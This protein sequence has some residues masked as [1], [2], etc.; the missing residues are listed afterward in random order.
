[1]D[2]SQIAKDYEKKKVLFLCTHNAIRSQMAEALLRALYGEYYDVYSAG[3]KPTKVHP[4]TIKV[5]KEIGIDISQQYSK[6]IE[7]FSGW[8]F[9]YVITV[10]DKAK[11]ECPFFP[12]GKKYL[13]KSFRDPGS[14]EGEEEKKLQAF[15]EVREE[16]RS[17]IIEVL[18]RNI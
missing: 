17:W 3:T 10:C 15:R 13:H 5:M 2:F 14:F 18:G 12:G 8:E 1:M 9:D 4:Y 16:I 11:E 6:S 7:E